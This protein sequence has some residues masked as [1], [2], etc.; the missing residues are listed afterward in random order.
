[1]AVI[2]LFG[3]I[4]NWVGIG[5]TIEMILGSSSKRGGLAAGGEEELERTAHGR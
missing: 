5:M 3:V 1:M 2:L 4:G